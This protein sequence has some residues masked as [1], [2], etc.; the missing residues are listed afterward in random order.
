MLPHGTQF[1]L[2]FFCVIKF[3]HLLEFVN[4][5]NYMALFTRSNR[6]HQIQDFFRCMRFWG[7]A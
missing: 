5:N 1:C 7:Y 6:F 2:Y 3:S 4:T